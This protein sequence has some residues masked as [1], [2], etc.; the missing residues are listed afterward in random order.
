MTPAQEKE[1]VDRMRDDPGAFGQL[2]DA[3]YGRIFSYVFR[4]V[5]DYDTSRDIVSETFLKA[6]LGIPR[7]R[8]K[9][10]SI[11]AWF[12]RIATNEINQ[13]FRK[14]K[15][16]PISFDRLM[17]YVPWVPPEEER[18]QF[19]EEMRRHDEFVSI[20][21]ALRELPVRYQEVIALR[22]F[23]DKDTREVSEILAK[24]EG[25][26]KSLLSRGLEKLRQ[27]LAAG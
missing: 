8:W 25:T 1:L 5:G 9:G 11:G 14:R 24:R 12:Y 15:Y 26:I 2:F 18:A 10:V 17:D 20:Q 27:K 22:Y 7:F 23:E 21:E 16:A 6:W 19:E 13:Y 4:R 3:F